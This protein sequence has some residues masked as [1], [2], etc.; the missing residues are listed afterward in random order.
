MTRQHRT[1]LL[2]ALVTLAL[3][4]LVTVLRNGTSW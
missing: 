2:V 1:A 3:I 4:L